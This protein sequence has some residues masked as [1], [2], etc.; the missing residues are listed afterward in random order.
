MQQMHDDGRLVYTK[1]GAPR[2]K[3][4][5]D[6]MKGTPI[7]TVWTDIH[8]INSQAQERLGY[9]TQKPVALLE[10]IIAASSNPGD[11]VLDPFCGCGT[12]VHAAEKL[13]RQWIGIDVTHLAIGLIKRRLTEAFAGIEFQIHGVPTDLGGAR[14]LAEAD[15]HEFEKWA[16]SLIPNA[17]PWK[18]GKKGADRGIDGVLYVDGP[19]KK[20]ERCIISVKGGANVGVAMVR[21]L[22][23]T[24]ERETAPMGLF[25]T[26]T[27]PTKPMVTEAAAAGFWDTDWGQIPRLQ[28]VTVEQLLT[29]PA[30]PVRIPMA[31]S[32]T[33]KKAAREERTGRQGALDI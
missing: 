33:Y 2:Y 31:R 17:Q 20:T 22:V 28:I 9:P 27:D 32:D 3:R 7:N 21:D 18:G 29:S 30:P 11:V 8:P 15:K 23:G 16:I 26:L 14:A 25:L 24:M 19:D 5:M 12:T 13:G 6:E 10:R 1:S 4:Y